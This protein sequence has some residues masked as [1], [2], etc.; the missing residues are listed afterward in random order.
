MT[1]IKNNSVSGDAWHHHIAEQ[2]LPTN[3]DIVSLAYWLE[4]KTTLIKS[5]LI[6]GLLVDGNEDFETIEG[7]LTHFSLIA[8]NFP[9]FADG[10]GYSLAKSLREKSNYAHEI[11]AVGDILP[12]Q[13]L[14]LTRVGF[15]A[16][17]LPT[18]EHAGLALDK[19][20][21]YS[22]FYQPEIA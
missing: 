6:L 22:V 7:E 5:G 21:E 15:D 14:Y 11:R 4:N 17:E 19:L 16:L 13:A 2:G 1:L 3:H 18:K 9:T 8:I 10:R 12:D 20:S